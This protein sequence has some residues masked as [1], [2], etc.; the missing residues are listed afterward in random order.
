MSLRII[1]SAI[2]AIV[3]MYAA[4]LLGIHSLANTGLL[5]ILGVEVTR[6]RGIRSAVNRITASVFALGAGSAIFWLC[7]FYP[8][9]VGLFV[10][11]VFT[12]LHHIR[13][14]EG[15]VTGTVVIFHLIGY[16]S[17]SFMFW[18][19]TFYGE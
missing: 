12:V 2:A 4:E 14:R 17:P 5:P 9:A 16:Q 11:L 3:A 10:L 8:W 15:I 13:N 7:G 18:M 1:K 6:R 19:V